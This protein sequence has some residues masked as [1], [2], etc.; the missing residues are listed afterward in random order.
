VRAQR[1]GAQAHSLATGAE[2]QAGEAAGWAWRAWRALVPESR[3]LE[4]HQ[5]ES[6]R[7]ARNRPLGL[8]QPLGGFLLPPF[9]LSP[10]GDTRKAPPLQPAGGR[11]PQAKPGG[12]WSTTHTG[13]PASTSDPPWGSQYFPA[14]LSKTSGARRRLQCSFL[15]ELQAGDRWRFLGR[16]AVTIARRRRLDEERSKKGP[17]LA[18]DR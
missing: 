5:A 16:G 2:A 14:A 13:V 9:A 12:C 10:S 6:V 17:G 8:P 7:S 1:R 18:G 11:R 3:R 15:R 4:A